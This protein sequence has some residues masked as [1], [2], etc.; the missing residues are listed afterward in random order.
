MKGG[1]RNPRAAQGQGQ[2]EPCRGERGL[3]DVWGTSQKAAKGCTEPEISPPTGP[4]LFGGCGSA[5]DSSPVSGGWT[6]SQSGLL[7]RGF[8]LFLG[9]LCRW[10]GA[11]RQGKPVPS[12]GEPSRAV[13]CPAA[14]ALQC[15]ICLGSGTQQEKKW[16]GAQILEPKSCV[17]KGKEKGD[18][19]WPLWKWVPC[20]LTAP[21]RKARG[22]GEKRAP[23]PW[24]CNPFPKQDGSP[25][26]PQPPQPLTLLSS[27][28]DGE[29]VG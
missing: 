11:I 27:G 16:P 22:T 8:W 14:P 26:T 17:K 15:H 5:S 7:F 25:Q 18:G 12:G 3:S 6:T 9:L 10:H 2:E 20:C 23:V 21:V 24:W 1:E 13:P 4:R 28:C 29:A 19:G